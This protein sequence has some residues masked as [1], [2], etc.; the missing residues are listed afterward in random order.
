MSMSN[1]NYNLED[2]RDEV[3]YINSPEGNLAYNVQLCDHWDNINSAMQAK[4]EAK[5]E[6]NPEEAFYASQ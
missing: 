1:V 4:V 5:Y 6:L 2:L 3:E